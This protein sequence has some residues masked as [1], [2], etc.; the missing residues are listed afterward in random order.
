MALE[1]HALGEPQSQ[2]HDGEFGAVL[3]GQAGSIDQ[4]EFFGSY[5][6]KDLRQRLWPRNLLIPYS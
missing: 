4:N 1:C 2:S 5:L 3:N 6:G